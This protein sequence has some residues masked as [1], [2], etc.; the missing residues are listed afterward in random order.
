MKLTRAVLGQIDWYWNAIFQPR[1]VG[2]TDDEY[3][4]EPVPDCWTVH[5]IG[6]GLATY[7][8]NWPPPLVPPVTTIAWRMAHVG[9]GCLAVRTSEYFPDLVPEPWPVARHQQPVPFPA[10]AAGALEFLERWFALWRAGV[11]SLGDDGLWNPI[12]PREAAPDMQL[13]EDD[14]MIGLVF[15]QHRELMHHGGEINLLRDLYVA[16]QPADPM[17]VAILRGDASFAYDDDAVE[18]LRVEEPALVLRA[19]ELARPAGVE[20]AVKLGFDINAC[21]GG[22]TALHHAAAGGNKAM[23]ELLLRLG[24]DRTVCD[25]TWK[26]TPAGWARHFS[27]EELAQLLEGDQA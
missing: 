22:L 13:G 5:D 24:A 14:P 26:M 12:G 19:S 23:A 17:R 25:P 10:T 4:W 6:D 2:L 11:E 16:H 18:R 7:D 27:Q 21:D 15:H 20:L 9:I 8:F 1:L 3:L